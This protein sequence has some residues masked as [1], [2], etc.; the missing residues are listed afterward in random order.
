[1]SFQAAIWSTKYMN[2]LPDRCFAVI[3]PGGKKDSEGKTTPRS[4][5]HFPYMDDKGTI[6]L[7]H[8]NNGMAQIMKS[9]LSMEDK[10]RVHSKLLSVYKKLGKAHAPCKV[11]GCQGYTPS[12]K[13]SMLE[14]NQTFKAL[15]YAAY[16][17]LVKNAT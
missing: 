12:S 7:P 10:K 3:E 5:R 1:M 2:D 6:D 9:N 4:L 11:P 17:E 14:D 15:R 13:K 16:Q 8:L